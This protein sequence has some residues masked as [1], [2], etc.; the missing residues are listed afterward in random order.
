MGK[1][2]GKIVTIAGIV[3]LAYVTAGTA[4]AVIGGGLPLGAALFGTIEALGYATG[5]G[6][7]AVGGLAVGG[8]ATITGLGPSIPK[9]DTSVT[10]I[11]SPLPPRVA[12][13]GRSRL[14]GAYTIF[15]TSG[16]GVAIDVYV[17]LDT[18]GVAIDG[19]EFLYLG[20]QRVGTAAG[21]VTGLPDGTYAEASVEID[22]RLGLATETAFAQIVALLPGIWTTAHRGDGCVTGMVT[23][24]P[25]KADKYQ[26]RYPNGQ[27]SLS[28]VARWQRCFDWRDGAQSVD[29]PDTWTW[30]ENACLHMA[31]YILV[32]E[33]S[34]RQ[35][36]EMFPSGPALTAAWNRYF[37]PTLAYWIA[38]ANDCDSP[39]PLKAGGTEPRYRSAVQHKLTDAHKGVKSK[40]AACFDGWV[41]PRADGALV[42]Y[43]GSYIAPDPADEIGPDEIVAYSMQ[44]GVEDES[45]VNQIAVSYVSAAH[46]FSTVDTTAWEDD[47]D[48]LSRGEIAST[49]LSNDVPSNGQ[50]R[51]LAKRSMAKAMAPRRGT[52]STNSAGRKIVGK[53]YI[54]L[55]IVE[56][57]GEYYVGPVEITQLTRNIVTGGVTFTWISVDP[58]IDEWNPATEEG[59]PAPVGD[60]VASEP[61]TDPVITSATPEFAYDSGAGTQGVCID[62]IITAPDRTDL[63][64]FARTRTVGATVWGER[65]Y[66][67]IDP[68][69]SVEIVTEFVPADAMVEVE[70]AYQV[71][72]GRVS[73]WSDPPTVVD[74]STAGVGPGPVTAFTATGAVGHADLQWRNSTTTNF[75]HVKI[76]RG[77]TAVFGAAVQIG[78]DIPGSPGAVLTY[79]DTVAA[80]VYRYWVRPYNAAGTAATPTGPQT[81]TVT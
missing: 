26:E 56:G 33:K 61:L 23:W 42:V 47:A 81:A 60:V 57:G 38:A 77:T 25:V 35:P 48:I 11:K 67:D 41:S 15:T 49:T 62:L 5:L 6:A 68:G 22:F 19:V 8:L 78:S 31:H 17:F 12:A 51:R 2:I 72:D 79:T 75:D 66:S 73:L 3:A 65:T 50:A 28:L 45:A 74:T 9:P 53:R 80:G 16:G 34:V 29:D 71:G 69:A 32:R 59:D 24:Q 43:S 37:A 27:P 18:G 1:T 20:D 63:T 14:Y 4:L 54:P 39:I 10:A 7:L 55:R 46:D 70:V 40:I 36:E 30:T 76:Y 52:V 64:W 21:V 44:E 13:Y 58:N